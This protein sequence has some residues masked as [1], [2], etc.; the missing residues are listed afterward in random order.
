LST[1]L[2]PAR[3]KRGTF[4]EEVRI[5]SLVAGLRMN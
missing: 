5:R 1:D 2:S 3:R 4:D